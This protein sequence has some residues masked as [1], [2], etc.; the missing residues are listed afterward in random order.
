MRKVFDFNVHLP[1]R[2]DR[3]V[4]Q[5]AVNEME[6]SDKDLCRAISDYKSELSILD[7]ANLMLFNTSLFDNSGSLEFLESARKFTHCHLTALVDF[8]RDDVIEYVDVLQQHGVQ[9]VKFHSYVQKITSDDFSRVLKVAEYSAE[10]GL[11]LCF[12]ASYGTLGMYSQDNLRLVCAVADRI[13]NSPIIILHSGG[14]RCIEA[15]LIADAAPNVFLETSFTLPYYRG[16]RIEQ[17]LLFVYQKIGA[18][19]ILYA[20]DFPYIR[21]EESIEIASGFFEKSGFSSKEI[22][23]V[24][25]HNSAELL[26]R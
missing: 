24:F 2:A 10:R 22:D 1:L 21:I 5:I 12:D 23:R 15:M 13:K 26:K 19:R 18:E 17:D 8:R 6:M 20:S 11:V 4:D 25:F 3:L 9:C 16:S 14:A 7:S